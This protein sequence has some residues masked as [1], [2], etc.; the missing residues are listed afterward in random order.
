MI[1][2]LRQAH[3]EWEAK[4]IAAC[5]KQ[6]QAAESLG[7]NTTNMK[8]WTPDIGDWLTHL[9]SCILVN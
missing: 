6:D 5:I 7:D 4:T 2:A 3:D 9:K 1:K 8:T